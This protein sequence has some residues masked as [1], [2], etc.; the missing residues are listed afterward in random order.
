MRFYGCLKNGVNTIYYPGCQRLF[1]GGFCRF[2]K[3][4]PLAWLRPVADTEAA[5]RTREKK[6][7][8][9]R[10]L[11][12]YIRTEWRKLLDSMRMPCRPPFYPYKPLQFCKHSKSFQN[13]WNVSLFKNSAELSSPV[14]HCFDNLDRVR[15]MWSAGGGGGVKYGVFTSAS[16][17]FFAKRSMVSESN[18]YYTEIF[19]FLVTVI[20]YCTC[21][22]RF[23][24]HTSTLLT[25]ITVC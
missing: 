20:L 10:N 6:T 15:L 14:C 7:L 2:G 22:L 25:F 9:Q 19:P 24:F 11:H 5:S 17:F 1:M 3:V 8:A 13:P 4:L 16:I 23:R 18:A 12:V 21:T